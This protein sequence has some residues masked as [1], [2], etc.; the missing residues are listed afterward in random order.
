MSVADELIAVLP[1]DTRGEIDGKRKA[2]ASTAPTISPAGSVTQASP[3]RTANAVGTNDVCNQLGITVDGDFATCPGCNEPGAAINLKTPGLKCSHNR[4]SNRGKNGFRT[5]VDL[6]AEVKGLSPVAACNWLAEQFG[7]EGVRVKS[8][9]NGAGSPSAATAPWS[10]LDVAGIFAPLD[11]IN[12]LVGPLDICPGAPTLIAGFGFSAKTVS[13]QC[14]GI[15]ISA[16]LP[17]WG[18]FRA[19]QGRVLHLDWEQG[20]RLTRGKYQRLAL[21]LGVGPTDLGDRLA[22][23]SMPPIFID[24]PAAEAVLR[25]RCAGYDLV[26]IDSL[27]AA[28]PAI[29]ENSSAARKPLDMLTRLSEALGCV[30]LVIHHARK[31]SADKPGGARMAIRGSGAIYDAC[32]SVFVFDGEPGR[33]VSVEHVKARTS[34]IVADPFELTVRDVEIGGVERA[35]LVVAATSVPKMSSAP[36]AALDAMCQRI[37]DCLSQHGAQRSR[38]AVRELLGVKR[39]DMC[40]A[41]D[42]LIQRGE[43]AE[44]GSTKNHLISLA[45]VPQ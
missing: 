4:C 16:N 10:V 13:A 29:E 15:E 1:A 37:R 2:G 8:A 44:T 33:P 21:G 41:L 11:P 43:V 3:F 32:G 24:D 9:S 22:L 27:H 40:G 39:N 31:P 6:V 23:L 7:F 38:A 36:T 34:G 19:R 28:C 42:V 20:S 5:N 14:M 25:E 45:E 35:G 18:T 26:I 30:F 12:Y 17:I